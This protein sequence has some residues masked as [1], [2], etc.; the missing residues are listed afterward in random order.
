LL[1][2]DAE[3]QVERNFFSHVHS[4]N[5]YRVMRDVASLLLFEKNTCSWLLRMRSGRGRWL[6][7]YASAQCEQGIDSPRIGIT[8][9]PMRIEA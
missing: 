9:E 6:W 2:F 5:Q 3:Q 4:R 8:L 1:E 7:F